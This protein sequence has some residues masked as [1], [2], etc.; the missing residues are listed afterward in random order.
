MFQHWREIAAIVCDPVARM[1][2]I[3][4]PNPAKAAILRQLAGVRRGLVKRV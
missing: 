4:A 2:Q 1:P 3:V